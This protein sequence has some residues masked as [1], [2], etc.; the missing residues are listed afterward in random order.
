MRRDGIRS[1]REPAVDEPTGLAI[2]VV[3]DDE[4]MCEAVSAR[5]ESWGHK[6]TGVGDAEA[7][8]AMIQN[9]PP[10]LV[11]ADVVLPDS[12][13]IDLLSRMREDE[14]R[15]P[16]VLMTAHA[17]VDLA[18]EAMKQGA[19]DFLT[20]PVEAEHLRSLIEVIGEDLRSKANIRELEERLSSQPGLGRLVGG[21]PAMLEIFELVRLL[22]RNEASAILG[23]E[24]GTGKE[25]VARSIHELSGRARRP[26]VA[27]NCAAIPAGLIESELFGHVKGAFTGATRDRPGCFE[28]ADGGI[29]L[30]DEIAEMPIELQPKLLRILEDGRATRVGG[31]KEV[32]F[33]VRVLAATNM[34]PETAIREG[35]LREDLYYRLAVFQLN[36]PPL[37]QRRDDIPLLAHAFVRESNR[38]HDCE[39]EGLQ[40]AALQTLYDY[41]WPGNVRELRNVI[42]RSVIVAGRGLVEPSHLPPFLR[43]VEA[44]EPSGGV[45]VLEM[46]TP[47]REAEKRL[48]LRTLEHVGQNKAEAAR[49]LGLDVKTIRNKL[50]R[51]AA[52][53]EPET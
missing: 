3:E 43:G 19:R 35:K 37:R 9:A 15:I 4:A 31:S 13:G 53:E 8:Y 23:G 46:G 32:A 7:A 44:S 29:L 33:D 40:E 1:S 21:S 41:G 14:S 25:L 48:I 38:K 39:V 20:K 22:A 18:V 10:D 30:L 12:S 16:V 24:S 26:F 17:E 36:L 28:L 47:A 51:Y 49:Q 2:L 27:L 45:I 5:L 42:E 34:N 11:L 52:D 50:A 6:V